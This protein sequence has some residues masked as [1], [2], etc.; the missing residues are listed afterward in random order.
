MTRNGHPPRRRLFG[1]VVVSLSLLTAAALG[2]V[3]IRVPQTVA[4]VD[5]VLSEGRELET[6]RRWGEAVT[7][8]EEAS[9][10][11]PG[12]H[13]L[14]QRLDLAKVHYDIGR[15]YADS[16]YRQQLMKLSEQ[17]ALD[18]YSQVTSRLFTHYVQPPNWKALVDRGTTSLNVAMYEAPF[19]EEH[20]KGVSSEA[21]ANFRSLLHQEMSRR[22]IRDRNQARD[23]VQYA[24]RLAHTHLRI[25]PAAVVFEYVCGALGGLDEYSTFLTA[26]QL[27]DIYSQ[28]DGNFVGLGVELKAHEHALLIV[29]VI[30]GS[31]AAKAG[32]QKAD[33]LTSVAGRSTHDLT[34]DQ[35]ADLLQGEAG[36]TV[37]L[38]AVS[39]EERPRRLV[40]RREHVEVPSIEDAKLL[41][42]EAGVAYLK[43]SVF[44]KTTAKDLD[45]ALWKLYR[46]GMKSLVMDLRGNPGGLLTSSVEVADK[47]LEQGSIVSTRGRSPQEDFNYSAQKQGT[48][49]VPLVVLLDGE[50]ASASEIFAGAMR[51]HRRATIV[52]TRS[53]GKGSVQGIFP[54]TVGN[55]G[56]RLTTAKFYSPNGHPYSRV[57]VEPDIYVRSAE[58]PILSILKSE[59]NVDELLSEKKDDATLAAGLQAARKQ[60]A[61]L[62]K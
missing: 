12:Q 21:I 59:V 16:T 26:A 3:S 27:T 51:D 52:G 22:Q 10:R 1:I 37:E 33:R 62:T 2:Q 11:N 50:S 55:T 17:Q 38:V 56:V 19:I 7:L 5:T 57:G 53:Y 40:V 9:R 30:P 24:A 28:I 60:L 45:A 32:I 25:R 18:V 35:A 39:G 4:E 6:Q 54:L 8:Y 44:Q 14:E 41:D 61:S 13:A 48:W 49:R 34:T 15:R 58:K 23:A 47:F 43:L 42:A 31:P 36:T 29:N 46:E 20:L